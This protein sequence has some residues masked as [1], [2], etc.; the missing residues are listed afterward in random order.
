[1]WED[2]EAKPVLGLFLP[3]ILR[4]NESRNGHC[5]RGGRDLRRGEGKSE[6]GNKCDRK[7]SGEMIWRGEDPAKR[8]HGGW[9]RAVE[10]RGE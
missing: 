10:E 3:L 8:G 9:E 6:Q 1:M 7:A 2:R 5:N 4:I